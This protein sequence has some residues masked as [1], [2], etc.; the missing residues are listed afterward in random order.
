VEHYL[1]YL[2]QSRLEQKQSDMERVLETL[3]QENRDLH[4]NVDRVMEMIQQNPKLAQV[5]PDV[6]IKKGS[7]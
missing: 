5:K 7:K 6:L 4:E 2:D 1:T 3:K